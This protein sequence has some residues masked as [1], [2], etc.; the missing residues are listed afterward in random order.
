MARRLELCRLIPV[1]NAGTL[2]LLL[3]GISANEGVLSLSVR[4]HH[5]EQSIL[6]TKMCAASSQGE[7]L[8]CQIV[9]A[10]GGQHRQAKLDQTVTGVLDGLFVGCLRDFFRRLLIDRIAGLLLGFGDALDSR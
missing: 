3:C 1:A 10:W 4:S 5:E 9:C 7:C 8:R 6:Q 2:E